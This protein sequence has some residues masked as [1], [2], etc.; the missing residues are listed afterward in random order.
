MPCRGAKGIAMKRVIAGRFQTQDEADNVAELITQHL[1]TAEIRIADNHMRGQ[2]NAYDVPEA[3]NDDPRAE[4]TFSAHHGQ[5]VELAAAGIN[6][7]SGPLVGAMAEQGVYDDKPRSQERRRIGVLL[8]VRVTSPSDEERV[9]ATLRAG[10]AAD[11]VP[12]NRQWHDGDWANF[13]SSKASGPAARPF[14]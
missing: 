10:G 5:F 12:E 8:S 14:R 13:K 3:E 4:G 9:I 1:G 6:A 2:D 11:I 7:Y